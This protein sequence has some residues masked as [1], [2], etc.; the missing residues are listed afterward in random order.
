MISFN[1]DE[2]NL[3]IGKHNFKSL[4]LIF[5]EEWK[6]KQKKTIFPPHWNSQNHY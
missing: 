5:S 1:D 2:L 6:E 3:E 4:L